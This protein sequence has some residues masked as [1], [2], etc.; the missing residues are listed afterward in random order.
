MR[1]RYAFKFVLYGTYC[2]ATC[3]TVRS[4][5]V[6]YV[7]HVVVYYILYYEIAAI[8]SQ[9]NNIIEIEHTASLKLNPTKLLQLEIEYKSR[10]ARPS[11]PSRTESTATLASLVA[12]E[13]M[14]ASLVSSETEAPLQKSL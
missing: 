8:K 3:V 6:L 2:G 4:C 14:L 13:Y 5:T 7:H 12:R 9:V 11:G 1:I 10:R